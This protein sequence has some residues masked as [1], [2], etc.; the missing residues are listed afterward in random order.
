[1]SR[2]IQNAAE[3]GSD[4]G[5]AY[6]VNTYTDAGAFKATPF[7]I[8]RDTGRVHLGDASGSGPRARINTDS[9]TTV[10]AAGGAT[11]L[12]ATPTGYITVS[13]NGTDRKIPF[14]AV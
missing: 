8:A 4:A 5:S 13:I 9:G 12:P 11:A 6:T 10:G 14:Y 3:S 2:G 7:M 1:M